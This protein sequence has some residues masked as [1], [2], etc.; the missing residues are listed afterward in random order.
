M[1]LSVY[2]F[3]VGSITLFYSI[4]LAN[5]VIAQTDL[6]SSSSQL[7]KLSLEELMDI[8]VSLVSKTP[9]KLTE[10]PSAIQVITSEDIRRSGAT[11]IAEALRLASNLMVA[12][13]NSHDWAITARGFNGAPLGSTGLANKLLVM[14]DG[15]NVYSPLF[16][17]VFWDA[18]N[19][20]LEDIERIEVVS[21]PGGSLWGAN[22]VNGVINIITKKQPKHKDG[23]YRR[24][25]EPL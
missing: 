3:C 25:P 6:T 20:L 17:G 19:V 8:E 14:I 4:F 11:Q 22:A 18:Q 21:G 10:V 24:P 15:R 13:T 2:K 5:N 1:K 7:K 12:Q 23:F 9:Q 16:G